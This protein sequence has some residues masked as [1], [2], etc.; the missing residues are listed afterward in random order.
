MGGIFDYE[1]MRNAFAAAT[2]VA[3]VSGTIGYFLVLRGETFAGHALAH[4]GFPGATG[5]V[6]IGVS[7]FLGLTLFTLLAG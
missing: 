2:I 4:V 6:L 7:P 1:F 5:A 3:L